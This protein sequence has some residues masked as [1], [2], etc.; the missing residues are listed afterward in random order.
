MIMRKGNS[1]RDSRGSRSSPCEVIY[2]FPSSLQRTS[3]LAFPHFWLENLLARLKREISSDSCEL[4]F[5]RVLVELD[6]LSPSGRPTFEIA[7]SHTSA[8]TSLLPQCASIPSRA[9]DF[10]VLHPRQL[11]TYPPPPSPL[12]ISISSFTLSSQVTAL[13]PFPRTI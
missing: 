1:D 2:P 7:S 4:D 5:S 6:E 13:I 8:Q 10:L 12:D 9:E 11:L 3:L